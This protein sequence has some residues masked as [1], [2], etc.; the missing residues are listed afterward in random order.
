MSIAT[1]VAIGCTERGLIPEPLIR[2]GIR[3][4]IRQRLSEIGASDCE[5]MADDTNAFVEAM[6]GSDIAP[7][8]EKAN[9]Q[10]YEVPPALYELILG[11]H[12]KYSC[13][14][15]DSPSRSLGDAERASL[16]IYAERA[17]V[18]DGMSV[19]D[20][21]CGWG[22]MSLYLA[23]RFP[24]AS[25]TAVSNSSSQRR[26]IQRQALQSGVH[27]LRVITADMN[28]FHIDHRF[29]RVV[30]IEMFE[31]M[32]NY[33]TL[34]GRIHDWLIPGGKLFMHIFCHRTTPYA[35]VPQDDSDWM[36]RYF[37]SGGIMPSENLPLRFQQH[38]HHER[39]WRWSGLHYLRTANAWLARMDQNRDRILAVL[40]DNYGAGNA[41]LWWRRWR[42]FFM[43]LGELFGFR[44]GQEWWVSHYRFI[45]PARRP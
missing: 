36:S 7:L 38:L 26:F 20:L 32:R 35:F 17:E 5:R 44:D 23:A 41:D 28:D 15:F 19:L 21:G 42:L 34:L 10:H 22:S 27:N 43:A 18:E 24:K 14:Y 37:F 16:D 39:M 31:H 6:N 40:T 2:S 12:R 11:P 8:P 29:D 4:L 45:R 30:S 33:R 3:H 9:E 25:I 1:R 13:C